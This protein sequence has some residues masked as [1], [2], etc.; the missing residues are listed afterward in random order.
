V[1]V[2]FSEMSRKA[3]VYAASFAG[4]FGAK[5][6]LLH[7]VEPVPAPPEVVYLQTGSI[8]D[9]DRKIAEEQMSLWRQAA[10]KGATVTA[11]VRSGIAYR[12]IIEAAKETKADLIVLGTQGRTGLAHLLLGST[13]ERVV[14]EAG[15][16][17]LV[18]RPRERDFIDISQ[19]KRAESNR[20]K[21]GSSRVANRRVG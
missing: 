17:V 13:A 21:A 2:D 4:Q 14:R 19:S 5:I 7:V 9:E 16:P 15:C 10:A 18:V 12:E 8:Y 20:H 11:K 3:L 6:L 1:P